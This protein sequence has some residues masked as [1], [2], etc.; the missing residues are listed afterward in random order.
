MAFADYD[1]NLPYPE[2]QLNGKEILPLRKSDVSGI[3]KHDTNKM[4]TRAIEE[5]SGNLLLEASQLQTFLSFFKTTLNRGNKYFNAPFIEYHGIKGYFAKIKSYKVN[6]NGASIV[7]NL[8]MTLIPFVETLGG[9][10]SP[11]PDKDDI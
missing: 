6:S 9:I 3:G 7:V 2:L 5:V 4:A 1:A 11:F 10:P 8:D